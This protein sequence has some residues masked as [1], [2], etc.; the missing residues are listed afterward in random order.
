MIVTTTTI[1]MFIDKVNDVILDIFHFHDNSFW[2]RQIFY[3]DDAFKFQLHDYLYC[4]LGLLKPNIF[5]LKK[6]Q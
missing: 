1:T 5:Y 3:C 6:K 2:A 4:Q